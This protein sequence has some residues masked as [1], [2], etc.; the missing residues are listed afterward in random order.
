M[1]ADK[2]RYLAQKSGE[3]QGGMRGGP[4]PPHR[5]PSGAFAP[6]T[7]RADAAQLNAV[8]PRAFVAAPPR[9][10]QPSAAPLP[11]PPPAGVSN[12]AAASIMRQKLL[13]AKQKAA[14]ATEAPAGAANGATG[15]G[16]GEGD[17][18][19][20]G[21]DDHPGV[22]V[23][24]G[25]RGPEEA[26]V[27][28]S[29][30]LAK[31]ACGSSGEAPPL[32]RASG[33]IKEDGDSVMEMWSDL[34]G[35]QAPNA[36]AEEAE[37]RPCSALTLRRERIAH[38]TVPVRCCWPVFMR[39]G[40]AAC[41]PGCCLCTLRRSCVRVVQCGRRGAACAHCGVEKTEAVAAAGRMAWLAELR[42]TLLL[43]A[44]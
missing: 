32:K 30:S 23:R 2:N 10:P 24:L 40:G 43:R 27:D 15:G 25:K 34:A 36:G 38:R 44:G 4:R 42:L 41:H 11:A 5:G 35:E 8:D 19:A 13:A 22:G 18:G 16:G 14:D 21:G 39:V 28:G 6:R 9:P 33:A 37:V 3:L 7:P 12:K 29:A 31:A 17:G 1:R 20:E 26:C